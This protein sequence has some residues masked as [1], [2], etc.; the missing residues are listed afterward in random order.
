MDI[1]SGK[2]IILPLKYSV[3]KSLKAGQWVRLTGY[4]YTVRDAAHKRLAKTI[5]RGKKIPIPLKEQIIYYTGPTASFSGHIIGS[6]GP[7]TSSR[8][9]KYTPVLLENGLVG[10]IGKGERSEQVRLAIKKYR[11]IYFVTFGGAGAFLSRFVKKCNIAA[12]PDLGTEAIYKI[13]F[14]DFPVMIGI[15]TNGNCF[16]NKKS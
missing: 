13:F 5:E 6:C 11:A 10:M 15:E 1:L 16:S 2:R 3:A 14:E 8:M 12:Y 9:D 7:T 4:V